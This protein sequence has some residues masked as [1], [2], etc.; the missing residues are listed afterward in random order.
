MRLS[1]LNQYSKW[2]ERG[3]ASRP[4]SLGR[5]TS[6]RSLA[7]SACVLCE[8]ARASPRRD[9][10]VPKSP[11]MAIIEDLDDTGQAAKTSNFVT[12]VDVADAS[13]GPA[14]AVKAPDASVAAASSPATTT[15]EGSTHGDDLEKNSSE[16]EVFQDCKSLDEANEFKARGNTHFK[17][18]EYEQA[19]LCYTHAI[20]LCPTATTSKGS[21]GTTTEKLDNTT[22]EQLAVFYANRAACYAKTG[23]HSNVVD[24]CSRCLELRP[25]YV[26]ALMRRA[27]AREALELPT[28][29]LEDV[30]RTLEIESDHREAKQCL[31]RLEKASAA[32]L[33]QQKEEMMGK[34]KDLGNS[35]LGNFGMSLDNFKAEKD[36]TTGSYN[37]SFQR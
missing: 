6:A 2:A 34:L 17:A 25:D 10:N 1:C 27:L 14:A 35:I 13:G 15:A 29:A 21:N 3:G 4:L 18:G 28:E 7:S 24:D 26:K 8:R 36:P 16:V 37:I 30:K 33:E 11:A 23:E 31:P 22:S 12:P 5:A 32:K 20:D 9:K 19:L